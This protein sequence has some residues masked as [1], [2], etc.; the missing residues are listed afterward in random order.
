VLII[1][2]VDYDAADA[3]SFEMP[4]PIKALVEKKP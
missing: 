2:T 3:A 1:K 4:A